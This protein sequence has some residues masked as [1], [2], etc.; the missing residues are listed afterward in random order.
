[1][2]QDLGLFILLAVGPLSRGRGSRVLSMGRSLSEGRMPSA[3]SGGSPCRAPASAP[4]CCQPQR[5]PRK[6]PSQ[7]MGGPEKHQCHLPHSRLGRSWSERGLRFLLQG[8]PSGP[9]PWSHCG[10]HSLMPSVSRVLRAHVGHGVCGCT[11]LCVD[12]RQRPPSAHNAPGSS[13]SSIV[14]AP[15]SAGGRLRRGKL[16]AVGQLLECTRSLT[17][18]PVLAVR[19]FQLSCCSTAGVGMRRYVSAL[20]ML[21][22]LIVWYTQKSLVLSG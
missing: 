1:M 17:A 3:I 6:T 4:F 15:L 18:R 10:Q 12:P 8:C 5:P 9:G 11:G 21:T 7:E 19:L 14:L 2:S 16:R 22:P 13:Q 20:E